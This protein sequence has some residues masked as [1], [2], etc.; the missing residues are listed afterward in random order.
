MS[1]YFIVRI[2]YYAELPA[3]QILLQAGADRTIARSSG[4]ACFTTSVSTLFEQLR[5]RVRN[6]MSELAKEESHLGSGRLGEKNRALLRALA[7][8]KVVDE[9]PVV[10]AVLASLRNSRF[11]KLKSSVT[12]CRLPS[13][14]R[15]L[16][17]TDWAEADT[18]LVDRAIA[19]ARDR[20]L[21]AES[22][23]LKDAI[24]GTLS[25][26]GYRVE[27]VHAGPNRVALKGTGKRSATVFVET[28]KKGT[29]DVDMLS[30]FHG[31]E[32]LQERER[33]L[34]GLA[35]KGIGMKLVM[36]GNARKKTAKARVVDVTSTRAETREEERRRMVRSAV[37]WQLV[38]ARR[39]Q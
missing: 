13:P 28:E 37:G 32:C 29:L 16:K 38:R 21:L 12:G 8:C 30:G 36:S 20:L 27:A 22:H 34:R 11:E 15:E 6:K 24:A 5:E 31:S 18:R 19:T 33:L 4:T 9:F 14:A 10:S 3:N 1:E 39:L 25:A 35:A 7:T 2:R 17:R 23:V 26:M